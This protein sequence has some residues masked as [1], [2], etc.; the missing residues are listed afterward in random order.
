MIGYNDLLKNAVMPDVEAL[1]KIIIPLV[2][3]G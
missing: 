2:N 3:T 1:G